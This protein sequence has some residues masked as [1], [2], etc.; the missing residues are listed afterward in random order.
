MVSVA[1]ALVSMTM[2]DTSVPLRKVSMK[3]QLDCRVA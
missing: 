3:V 1:A 2:F